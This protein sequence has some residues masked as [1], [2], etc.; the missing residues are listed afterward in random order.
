MPIAPSTS[1][2]AKP[3]ATNRTKSPIIA[4]L[5]EAT[6][7]AVRHDRRRWAYGPSHACDAAGSAGACAQQSHGCSSRGSTGLGH[8]ARLRP[9]VSSVSPSSCCLG[10]AR[11]DAS[12]P[13]DRGAAAQPPG[14]KSLEAA[15]LLPLAAAG[16]RVAAPDEA[17]EDQPEDPEIARIT[18]EHQRAQDHDGDDGHA[19]PAC[20]AVASERGFVILLR[21]L[22]PAAGSPAPLPVGR[23]LSVPCP[24]PV[25][26]A[27]SRG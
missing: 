26:S 18:A 13:A 15:G 27:R 20:D 19:N 12:F 3:T 23:Q 8:R 10:N 1:C 11:R 16:Q 7:I 17:D 14:G 5:R 6:L 4:A 9:S 24:P 2:A 22:R 21:T 25:W